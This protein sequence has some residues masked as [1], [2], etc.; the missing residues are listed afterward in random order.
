M[1]KLFRFHRGLLKE[2]LAT[3][4]EVS[5]LAELR[6]KIADSVAWA[7]RNYFKNIRIKNEVHNDPR[8][9]TEWGGVSYYVLADFDDGTGCVGMCNFYEE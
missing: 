9:P 6:E 5:G 1:K 7:N 3:T 2:S 8:L 4:T